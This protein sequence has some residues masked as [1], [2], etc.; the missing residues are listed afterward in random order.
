MNAPMIVPMMKE[1]MVTIPTS[2][3]VQGNAA[4]MRSDTFWGKLL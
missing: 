1:R 3:S 4:P 2:V